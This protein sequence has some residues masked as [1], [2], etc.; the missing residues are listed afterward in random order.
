M[1]NW[2][3][4]DTQQYLEPF[5]FVDLCESEFFERELFDHFTVCKQITDILLNF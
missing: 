2:S 4:S 5:N 3:V 1:F